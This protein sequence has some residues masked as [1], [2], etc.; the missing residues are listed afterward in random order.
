MCEIKSLLLFILFCGIFL[1]HTPIDA[2]VLTAT[3][4]IDG[5]ITGAAGA[6]YY[7]VASWKDMIDTY[8]GVTPDTASNNTIYYFVTADIPGDPSLGGYEYWN[9]ANGGARVVEGKHVKIFGN[10]KT[11]HLSVTPNNDTYYN[12]GVD[13]GVGAGWR[14]GAF[15][16]G[17][18]VTTATRLEV[19]N[20]KIINVI[21]GGIFQAV[22]KYD[23]IPNMNDPTYAASATFVYDN[24]TVVNGHPVYAAMPIRN[25]QGKILFTGT[26][27]FIINQNNNFNDISDAAGADNQGEWIEGGAW[28][29]VVNGTTTVEQS[30][31]NDQPIY[32]VGHRN[33]TLK[34]G[35]NANLIWNLN[36]TYTMYYD[37]NNTGSL[38]WI[39]GNNASFIINGTVNTATR[40]NNWWMWLGYTSWSLTVGNN[41][42]FVA[43]TG[44]GSI[45][46]NL[47]NNGPVNWNFAPGSQVLL[48]NL[49]ANYPL[50]SGAPGSGSSVTINDSSTFT[51]N[52]V[53]GKVFNADVSGFPITITGNGLRT[54]SSVNNA[55][56]D[57]TYTLTPPN[58]SNL[59]T[60]DIWYRQN[61]GTITGLG[62]NTPIN[63]LTPNPY[64]G[65][66]MTAINNAKYVSWYQPLGTSM[67]GNLSTMTR[68]F[69]IGLG[70][71]PLDGS[72]SGN[73]AGKDI[74]TLVA[75]DDRG[76]APSF[77]VTITMINNNIADKVH[78]MWIDPVTSN[79]IALNLNQAAKIASVVSD[80]NLPSFI[81]MSG[82]GN[83]Y[84]M[85]FATNQ[86]LNIQANNTLKLQTGTNTG[87]F[88]Y[89]I[90]SGP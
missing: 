64:N 89:S 13:N 22:G 34:V 56:F 71:L 29:E 73:I 55:T 11:L 35:D 14:R 69:D 41:G 60:N 75:R 79:Q 65:A 43:S 27:K 88:Q 1:I 53:G 86:G 84:T 15:R 8:N 12:T 51:L 28:I 54:H 85:T 25:D 44:G 5:S 20:A 36:K 9:T 87:T 4:D 47:F 57:T 10:G 40:F 83:Q 16:V 7:N 26:N 31:G 18:G 70:N 74:Q 81:K 2:A 24:V 3:T 52:T 72:F 62:T 23:S 32:A 48:N 68:S 37:D 50:L 76:Q 78:F 67:L 63:N 58:A 66:D 19:S 21:T 61:T 46:L 90:N 42:K 39:I 49:N 80:T 33:A 59:A 6:K 45:G 77:N 38:N 82:Q 30:W 17:T